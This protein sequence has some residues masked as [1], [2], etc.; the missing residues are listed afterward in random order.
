MFV[1]PLTTVILLLGSRDASA[2]GFEAKTMRE[3][4]PMREVE[5]PLVVG[6]GW[7][8]ADI[9]V[10]VKDAT[11]YWDAKGHE[12]DF[13]DARWL[14]STESVTIRYGMARRG[15]LGLVVPLHYLRLT[16]DNLGTDTSY[17]GFGDPHFFYKFELLRTTA[18]TSSV[19]L[20]GDY[21]GPAASESP[22]SYLG[23]P[24]AVSTFVVSTG[25]TDVDIGARG[26]RQLGPF[27][28]QMG[29]GYTRRFSGIAM[30]LVDLETYQFNGRIKP[31]D[32]AHADVMLQGQLGPIALGGDLLFQQRA[33]TRVGTT[34]LGLAMT[35]NLKPVE[36][37]DGWSLD[38]N[39][40]AIANITHGFDFLVGVGLPVRGED[41]QFFPLEELSPTYGPTFSGAVKLRY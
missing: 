21:K 28:A 33:V 7:F 20:F 39:V 38:L 8:E 2:G 14:Y 18:P 4:M 30:Y 29:L 12:K 9:G 35:K 5:R 37:S 23:G 17:F 40:Q 15:E 19:I 34:S 16:N 24:N 22:G 10:D 27:A 32:I 41:F 11:G 13:L 26:K 1:L 6:K 36:G 31:G 25:T 3:T